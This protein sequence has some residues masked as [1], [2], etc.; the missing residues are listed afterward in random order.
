MLRTPVAHCP[1]PRLFDTAALPSDH[2]STLLGLIY[3]GPMEETPWASALEY[4][5][6]QLDASFATLVLRTPASTRPGLIVNASI[7][8]ASLPG[9]PAYS[10]DYYALCPFLDLPADQVRTADELF[11]A[12]GWHASPFYRQYLQALDLRY[13]LAA[14]IRTD[15]GVEC[16]FFV[17]RSHGMQDYS[18]AERDY[19]A[20]LLPHLKRAVSLHAQL[21]AVESERALYAGTIDSMLIG[22][23]ILDEAGKVLKSNNAADG[24]IAAGDGIVLGHGVLGACCPVENRQFQKT[25][26]LALA[27]HVAASSAPVEVC[28]LSRNSGKAPLSVLIRP[29][30]LNYYARQSHRRPAVAVFIRDPVSTS[31]TSRDCMRKLFKLTRTETELALLLVDGLTLDQAAI[32]LGI[33]KNTVRAHLRGIFTKTGATRQATLV[34]TLLSSVISL[35]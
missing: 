24:L 11:G 7:Y 18:A 4:I 9:E 20:V 5:R 15:D 28:T 6:R 19:V 17:S 1:A 13:I 31:Q 33:M 30:P 2:L 16:A 14:N 27:R 26:R 12:D 35:A 3:Q 8:G 34:K 25:I 29:I 32:E 21:D 10:N 22:T 23:V